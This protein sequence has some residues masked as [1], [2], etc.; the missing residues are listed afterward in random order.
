MRRSP[1]LLVVPALLCVL[2]V[3]PSADAFSQIGPKAK[4]GGAPDLPAWSVEMQ[5]VWWEKHNSPESWT[6][7]AAELR[8]TLVTMQRLRGTKWAMRSTDFRRWLGHTW[9]LSLFPADVNES[10]VFARPEIRAAYKT[11]A[12]DPELPW[13]FLAALRAEDDATAALG[14]LCELAASDLAAVRAY[15][16][17]AIAT[18]VVW[19]QP[20]PDA[21]PHSFVERRNVPLGRES[22]V[23][24]FRFWIRAHRAGMLVTDPRKLS[25]NDLCFVINNP[26]EF[27]ELQYGQRFRL[28]TPDQLWDLYNAVEYD[29]DRVEKEAA[30]GW[31][32]GAYRLN[33]IWD[34]GGICAD[35]AYLAASVFQA[36][37]VPSILFL[38]QGSSG[39]HAWVGYR[40][41][42]GNWVL[43]V[44][45]YRNQNYPV[46]QAYHPQTRQRISDAELE[47][48]A[49]NLDKSG[50]WDR[51]R[52]FLGWARMNPKQPFYAELVSGA[53][54]LLPDLPETWELE[55][56]WCQENRMDP[57]RQAAFYERWIKHFEK[58]PAMRFR[59]QKGLYKLYQQA[60]AKRE[61]DA[62]KKQ[63]LEETRVKRFDLGIHLASEEIFALIERRNWPE[64][65]AEFERTMSTFRQNA[66]G[67][68]FYS[69]LQPYVVACLEDRQTRFARD[70]MQHARRFDMSRT[71]ILSNDI[72]RLDERVKAAP[73]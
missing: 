10:P 36:K 38:G 41:T 23:D 17:L 30:P 59:G 39:G 27:A 56:R 34:Q 18:A 8:A 52:I 25:V 50:D 6:T 63:M 3:F 53:R 57:K 62:L 16:N 68:L 5:R 55:E 24:R 29:Y 4:K 37:G 69:L 31:Q 72:R 33:A 12:L 19:D 46:G 1:L 11:L 67:H 65:R 48:F 13:R 42:D 40:K 54:K 32:S 22:M 44:A 9:W 21:W 47:S 35:Q 71:T 43:D 28:K 7:Q 70:A 15:P 2:L 73:R 58:Q 20:L 64:A 14:I 49:R 66:G 51:A 60:G 26:L 61:A 45:R